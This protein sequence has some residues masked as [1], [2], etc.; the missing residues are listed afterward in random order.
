[1][2]SKHQYVR[3]TGRR[4]RFARYFIHQLVNKVQSHAT[5]GTRLHRCVH[6][7]GRRVFGAEGLAP[8]AE[9]D[10]YR[11]VR[12]LYPYQ[13]VPRKIGP[14]GVPDDVGRRLFHGEIDVEQRVFGQ[15]QT[16]PD[17]SNKISDPTHIPEDG[18]DAHFIQ[19]N[20]SVTTDQEIRLRGRAAERRLLLT[21][22]L[23]AWIPGP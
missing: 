22:K 15:P 9:R 12:G 21:G 23:S 19:E 4:S 17:S 20:H 1:M 10:T 5:L 8:V 3:S 14:V 18:L 13:Y 7:E 11:V 2:F 6:V 16:T